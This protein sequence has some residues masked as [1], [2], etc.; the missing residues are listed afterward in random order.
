MGS[1]TLD[2]NN[3]T[4]Q[5]S[6]TRSDVNNKVS[7][8]SRHDNKQ[9]LQVENLQVKESNARLEL[10]TFF[11]RFEININKKNTE[12]NESKLQEILDVLRNTSL[13]DNKTKKVSFHQ[14]EV[15]V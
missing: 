2:L 11:L 8:P 10:E 9:D 14:A 5:S 12:I 6:T 3:P 15:V 13:L 4:R 7:L 1:P